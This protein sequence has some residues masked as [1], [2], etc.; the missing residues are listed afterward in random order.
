MHVDLS[1][2]N[3]LNISNV[4]L[5]KVLYAQT[6]LGLATCFAWAKSLKEAHRLGVIR[7]QAINKEK[8][9]S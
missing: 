3:I 1:R 9:M 5:A 4:E 7:G 6:G 2:I 8:V